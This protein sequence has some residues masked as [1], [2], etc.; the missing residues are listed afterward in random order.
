MKYYEDDYDDLT[1]Q[2]KPAWQ[3]HEQEI[4]C[5]FCYDNRTKQNIELYFFDRANNMRLCTY[6]PSCGRELV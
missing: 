4:G 2:Q 1:P 5:G 3:A 6:C